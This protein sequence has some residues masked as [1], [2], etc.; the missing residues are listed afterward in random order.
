MSNAFNSINS[1]LTYTSLLGQQGGGGGGSPSNWSSYPALTNVNLGGNVLSNVGSIQM[2]TSGNSGLISNA[3]IESFSLDLQGKPFLAWRGNL[4]AS[5]QLPV[6][7]V[8]QSD[9]GGGGQPNDFTLW[10]GTYI[11]NDPFGNPTENFTCSCSFTGT[12][13]WIM[14]AVW[15]GYIGIPFTL[16]GKPIQLLHENE[17][18]VLSNTADSTSGVLACRGGAL[19][20]NSNLIAN[21]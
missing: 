18:V 6:F 12:D 20:W 11:K 19:Y 21:P 8:K 4:S 14:G 9:G 13:G 2:D 16:Y 3:R 1:F 10:S 5:N 15:E 7:Q 17:G